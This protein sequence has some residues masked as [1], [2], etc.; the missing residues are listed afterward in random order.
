MSIAHNA[1]TLFD[2]IMERCAAVGDFKI[3]EGFFNIQN[4]VVQ[5]FAVQKDY[6]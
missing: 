2:Q 5:H 1:A 3:T 4:V 6:I